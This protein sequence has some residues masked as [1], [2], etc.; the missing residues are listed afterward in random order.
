MRKNKF[1]ILGIIALAAFTLG[2]ISCDIESDSSSSSSRSY[3]ESVQRVVFAENT[4]TIS[5]YNLNSNDI[6]LVKVNTTSNAMPAASTG[7]ALNVSLDLTKNEAVPS[8][9]LLESQTRTLPQIGH[10]QAAK[11]SANPPPFTRSVA[12]S[13]EY[14][15]FN[16]AQLG[17]QRSFWVETVIDSGVWVQR[18]ATLMA[19][20]RN[21]NIW[22][23]DGV[24]TPISTAQARSLSERFDIIYPAA[25]SL[26]GFEFGGGPGGHGGVDGDPKVQILVY[27]INDTQGN[28]GVAGYF[29][30]KDLFTQAQLSS[31]GVSVRTNLAEI[32]Y[33]D[34]NVFTIAPDFIYSTLVHELQHMINFN[35]KTITH[36]IASETWYNEMLSMVAEDLISPKVGINSTNSG[37]P[38]Q[39][40]I[41]NFLEA[42]DRIGATEWLGGSSM[43]DISDQYG[44][45]YAFGAYLVRN[46]GGPSLI[47]EISLNNTIGIDSISSALFNVAGVTFEEAISRFG[48]A[49]I[50]SGNSRPG[51]GMSF[52]RTVSGSAGGTRYTAQAFDIWTMR[53][54]RNNRTG[55]AV[56]VLTPYSM[57]PHSVLVQSSNDWQN[58]SGSLSVTLERPANEGVELFLMVR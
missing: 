58:V 55:P 52:D 50:F 53:Q 47:R 11:F 46:F 15:V 12:R 10:P 51:G 19:T 18:T 37:H 13:A 6:F 7:R 41:P 3:N 30:A 45:T 23:A 40:R 26:L 54:A 16:P 24:R 31:A 17:D 32:F 36:N 5:F 43:E 38:V 21:G 4:A 49:L 35:V 56:Y 34:A 27:D 2:F 14:P 22:I 20:G 8:R 1:F 44:V 39:A 42:Y 48:E 25:T 57:R 9:S 33:I 29:W 28:P